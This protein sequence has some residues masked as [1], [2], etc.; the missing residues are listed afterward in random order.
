MEKLEVGLLEESLGGSLR[1][2]RVGDDDIKLVLVVLQELEAVA[3]VD[4]RLGAVESSGHMGEVLLG[5]A[6]DGLSCDIS[7]AVIPTGLRDSYL[8]DVAENGRLDALVLDNLAEDAS[9][10]TSDHEDLLGVGVGVQ[11]EMG[12]HLLVRELVTL[13]ALDDVV[14]DQDVSVVGALEDQ[15]LQLSTMLAGAGVVRLVSS[16]YRKLENKHPGTWTSR[17]EGSS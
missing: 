4:G 12:D 14:K 3:D 16:P 9:V 7:K 8:I 10:T 11:G 15:D 2:R 6:D 17:R 5:E 1:V 13:S